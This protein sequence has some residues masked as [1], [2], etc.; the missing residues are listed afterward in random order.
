VK[1]LSISAGLAGI[2]AI[3]LFMGTTSAFANS[4][5]ATS[6][7][8]GAVLSSAP[9]AI[10]VT[11]TSALSD[12]GTTL[13]VT[14]P[15]GLRVDDGSLTIND[16]TAVIGLK[17]LIA[18]GV[19]TVTYTL[20]SSTDTP[21]TGSYTFLFNAPASLSSPSPTPSQSASVPPVIKETHTADIFVIILMLFAIFVG[22]FLLWYARM[23]LR[24]RQ[25]SKR[26]SRSRKSAS[27]SKSTRQK[28]ADEE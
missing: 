25:S 12:Q 22:I 18:A 17:P 7:T 2:L 24:E 4:L 21:L 27:T 28:K 3:G 9:N 14:D 8:S 11:G 16:T 23:L 13:S 5:T 6:P 1:K 15:S 20:V 19:Y 26:R 10:S